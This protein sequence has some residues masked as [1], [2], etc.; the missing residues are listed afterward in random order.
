[1]DHAADIVVFDADTIADTATWSSPTRQAEGIDVV[2]VNGSVAWQAGESTGSRSGK[3]IR[4]GVS[5]P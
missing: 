1:V 2:V 5:G 4:P 3:V